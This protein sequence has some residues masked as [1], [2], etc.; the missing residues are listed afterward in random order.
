[1]NKPACI[2][3]CV[4]ALALSQCKTTHTTAKPAA[5]AVKPAPTAPPPIP[6]PMIA[7]G[8]NVF[9]ANCNRCHAQ[10]K[11]GD[12]NQPQWS[13]IMVRMSKKAHLSDTDTQAVLAYLATT[14]KQ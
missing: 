8:R 1:M 3:L 14:A 13:D 12:Y 2:L 6:D 4:I 10:P 5:T 7:S 9:E 11:P